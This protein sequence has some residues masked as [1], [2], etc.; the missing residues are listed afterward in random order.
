[1][2]KK[3]TIYILAA[4]LLIASFSLTGCGS[5]FD[6]VAANQLEEDVYGLYEDFQAAYADSDS[7]YQV[8]TYLYKWA[9]EN[10]LVARKLGGGNLLI[11]KPPSV[12]DPSFPYTVIQCAIALDKP[13]ESSQIAAI[14]LAAVKNLKENGKIGILF[15]ATDNGE[16]TGAQRLSADQLDA[17]YF[18]H[19]ENG[20]ESAV[21]VGSAA[22]A[23]YEM[24]FNYEMSEP[25]ATIAYQLSISGLSEEDSSVLKGAHPNAILLLSN[26]LIG[27]RASGMLVEIADFDGGKEAGKYPAAASAI[28]MV[29]QNNEAKLQSRFAT[30]LENFTDKYSDDFPELSYTLS[31][32]SPPAEVIQSDD[33]ANLLS[34]LYTTINGV[35]KTS[36]EDGEGTTLAVANIGKLST[37]SKI[38]KINILAR[39][40]DETLL[41]EMTESYHATAF[42]SDAAFRTVSQT[43]SWSSDPEQE[44]AKNFIKTAKDSGLDGLSVSPTF[45]KSECVVYYTKKK[46]INMISFSVNNNDSFQDAKALLFFMTSLVHVE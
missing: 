45:L 44:F 14:A 11:T 18:I 43:E 6:E 24:S 21:N 7:V 31:P 3:L 4:S 23:E 37:S 27:C 29:N 5:D 2:R 40:V 41:K 10:N 39:S 15:T 28:I 38:M 22:T 12:N 13:K 36:E 35:Y 8:S 30:S 1:M 16:H 19:L 33:A 17:D 25:T 9:G 20:D 46:D 34:L 32:V 26:F 42:L